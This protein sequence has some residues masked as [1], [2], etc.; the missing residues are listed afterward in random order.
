MFVGEF[1][2]RG[3]GHLFEMQNMHF[4]CSVIRSAFVMASKWKFQ[5]VR[6]RRRWK[7]EFVQ[8]CKRTMLLEPSEFP[9]PHFLWR[10]GTLKQSVCCNRLGWWGYYRG[11]FSIK[12][13]HLQAPFSFLPGNQADILQSYRSPFFCHVFCALG[14]YSSLE[15]ESVTSP[16]VPHGRKVARCCMDVWE[17]LRFR[18][19][20]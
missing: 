5:T 7:F 1:Y 12:H 3:V 20:L 19:Q 4:S 14:N 18:T 17:T 10:L 13:K 16:M 15:H 9:I 6:C 11:R 2:S 8:H